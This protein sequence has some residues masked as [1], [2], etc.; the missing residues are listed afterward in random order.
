MS[1]LMLICNC[2]IF[3]CYHDLG[4]LLFTVNR[5]LSGLA[6]ATIDSIQA[7][8]SPYIIYSQAIVAYVEKRAIYDFFV[9]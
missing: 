4:N 2:L 6:A 7:L 1:T 8:C 3:R 5:T 9:V